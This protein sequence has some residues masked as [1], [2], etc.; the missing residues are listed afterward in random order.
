VYTKNLVHK[1][2][3][4]VIYLAISVYCTCTCTNILN[5]ETIAQTEY[6][7]NF[8]QLTSQ[9]RSSSLR[10]AKPLCMASIIVYLVVSRQQALRIGNTYWLPY[11]ALHSM[12][13]HTLIL[14]SHPRN[15]KTTSIMTTPSV[16]QGGFEHVHPTVTVSLSST[17]RS[18]VAFQ[19]PHRSVSGH[20]FEHLPLSSLSLRHVSRTHD[21]GSGMF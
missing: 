19:S 3:G 14:T 21:M 10:L 7:P 15:S 4:D 1:S 12:F 20:R 9:S 16:T 13:C 17:L 5:E 18:P 2:K 8:Q 11:I 6:N